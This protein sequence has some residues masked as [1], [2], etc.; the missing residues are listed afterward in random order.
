MNDQAALALNSAKAYKENGDMASFE[1][2]LNES[3]KLIFE[4]FNFFLIK[5][6]P[7]SHLFECRSGSP[8]LLSAIYHLFL[9]SSIV[10]YISIH[11]TNSVFMPSFI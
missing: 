11:I 4:V 6:S 7:V 10:P 8:H 1:R 5:A 3:R 9:S 2:R